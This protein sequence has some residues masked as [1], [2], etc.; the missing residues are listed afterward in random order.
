MKFTKF[1]YSIL[2]TIYVGSIEI[3]A[4][5][6]TPIP[7]PIHAIP[8]LNKA[9]AHA[10]KKTIGICQIIFSHYKFQKYK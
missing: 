8:F 9:S 10:S 4:S 1:S 6:A 5:K 2:Q 7:V 3:A